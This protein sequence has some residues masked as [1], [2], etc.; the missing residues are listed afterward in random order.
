M[1]VAIGG[2]FTA[3]GPSHW[4]AL[5]LFAAG[6]AGLVLL[7]RAQRTPDREFSDRARGFGR[8]F[9]LAIAYSMIGTHTYTLLPGHWSVGGAL[10]LEL[11]DLA[12]PVA[13]WALWTFGRLP[14]ALLY[15]WG[16]TIS[17]QALL[18]PAMTGTDYPGVR[19]LDFFGEHLLIVWAAVY[20]TW[21]VGMRPDWGGY[22]FT[23]AATAAWAAVAFVV[24]LTAGT[25]FGYLNR[26]PGTGSILSLMG[27]WPWYLLVETVIILAGWA[28]ITWPWTALDRPGP[29]RTGRS[30]RR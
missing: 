25:D 9:S 7:G 22:R 6:C 19:Y 16:L 29:G 23:I 8:A 28:L 21:G 26:K 10:P 13:I 30:P 24:N 20:L 5:G 17:V 11:C 2:R 3:Y 1:V 27:P 14:F 4:A 18:T 15:Y 12:W